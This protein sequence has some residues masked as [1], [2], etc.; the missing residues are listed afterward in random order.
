MCS[1]ISVLDDTSLRGYFKRGATNHCCIIL[2]ESVFEYHQWSHQMWV[3][4]ECYQLVRELFVP[5]LVSDLYDYDDRF[6]HS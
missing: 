1:N 2:L 4:R 5:V 3:E 6:G